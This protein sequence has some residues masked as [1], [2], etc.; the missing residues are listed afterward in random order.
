MLFKK[1]VNYFSSIIQIVMK[2]VF[3]CFPGTL[4][5]GDEITIA[6]FYIISTGFHECWFIFSWCKTISCYTFLL[7][8]LFS[9]TFYVFINF[10]LYWCLQTYF[11][12]RDLFFSDFLLYKC[13]YTSYFNEFILSGEKLNYSR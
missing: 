4:P 5:Q 10:L 13:T 6:L 3:R 12:H 1:R 7:C 8:F 2:L 11:V 9:K